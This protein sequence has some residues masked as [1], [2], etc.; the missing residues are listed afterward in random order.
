MRH[1]SD[2]LGGVNFAAEGKD[3]QWA[4]GLT[5]FDPGDDVYNR[6]KLVE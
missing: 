5:G 3:D 6:N 4:E 1:F 2:E